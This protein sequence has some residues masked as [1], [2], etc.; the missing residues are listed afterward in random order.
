MNSPATQTT[1]R[2]VLNVL[3]EDYFHV[4]A[5]N[6][7]IRREQWYRFQTRFEENTL[8]T[9]DLLD[10]YDVRATFFAL[11]WIADEQPELVREVRRRGHEIGNRGYFHRGVRQMSPDEF[12][13]DLKRSKDAIER[14]AEQRVIGFRA[15]RRLSAPTDLWTLDTLAL[16][17]YRYDTSFVPSSHLSRRDDWRRFAYEH[18]VNSKVEQTEE[19][20][21]NSAQAK[22]W[23]FPVP[24]CNIGGVL[25][26]IAGGNFF[27]QFP[28]AFV[29]R[30]VQ[31]WHEH[32]AQ[33]FV[34]YFHV[35]ELDPVQ[36]RLSGLSHLT[37]IRHYR[38]LDKMSEMLE[39]YF[40][41]YKFTSNAE[42]LDAQ[43]ELLLP[44]TLVQKQTTG[45]ASSPI[46]LSP[47]RSSL[48]PSPTSTT[49]QRSRHIAFVENSSQ[50][51]PVSIVVPCYNEETTLGYLSKT[52]Q[53]VER[54]LQPEYKAHF[55]FVNDAST[56]R[57]LET[58]NELFGAKENCTVIDHEQNQGVA[59]AIRTGIK[60]AT[61]E[62][63][64]SLDCDCT[65][66]PH[67]LR[68]ML[69]LLTE[70]VAMVTASP[71][72]PQGG[73]RNV[74]Q[75]R[76]GLSKVSSHL[77]RQVL[78]QKLHTYTSCFR[79]YRRSRMMDLRGEERGFL[80]VAEM[81]G[82]LDL[83]GGKIVEHPAVLEVRLF[84]QSKMKVLKTIGGHLRLLCKL[85]AR[86][87]RARVNARHSS[88]TLTI[89][90]S[91]NAHQ[92]LLDNKEAVAVSNATA[93]ATRRHA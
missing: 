83:A 40:K 16:E 35:W 18:T 8:R 48:P 20:D 59:A 13:D 10:R 11:G 29:K 33:P 56:D 39:H 1:K 43:S 81:L 31:R 38:N 70:D 86:R 68:N 19:N 47:D 32:T 45:V 28:P 73:V 79:V 65:Y 53:S 64:C 21:Q 51:V 57:T 17:G 77:Y 89:E 54:E 25:V 76:L 37:R 34:M 22:I 87:V 61:T 88:E 24:T 52:L 85:S 6:E 9:L 62:I 2:H 75:W 69:P 3:L 63:V 78:R 71:Y 72:H 41:Q 36:P 46:Y 7:R 82:E 55:I 67:E 66:D 93:A 49:Q 90:P 74:P 42:Y 4:G 58:L 80:G 50:G 12:R 27:R 92:S 23:E 84:G 26:P 15:A 60:Q 5:F 30:A 91:S 44:E 14:A